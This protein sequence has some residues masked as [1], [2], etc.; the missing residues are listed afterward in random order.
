MAANWNSFFPY[1]EPFCSW[2]EDTPEISQVSFSACSHFFV[3]LSQPRTSAGPGSLYLHPS[4]AEW[5]M[6]TAW[7]TPTGKHNVTQTVVISPGCW[8]SAGHASQMSRNLADHPTGR[9]AAFPWAQGAAGT[10]GSW[11]NLGTTPCSISDQSQLPKVN[12]SDPKCQCLLPPIQA[13][14]AVTICS[15]KGVQTSKIFLVTVTAHAGASW[16]L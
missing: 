3:C 9:A 4:A 8:M 10:Q 11:Y 14:F 16:V 6:P 12:S 13:V 5:C 15:M 2:Q 1:P 7:N